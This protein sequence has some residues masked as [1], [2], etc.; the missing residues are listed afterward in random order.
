MGESPEPHVIEGKLYDRG[1]KGT[2]QSFQV[3]VQ[4]DS[5][6]PKVAAAIERELRDSSKWAQRQAVR[7]LDHLRWSD[8][9]AGQSVT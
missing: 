2:M 9:E 7:T 8:D 1:V 6:K 3:R 4:S 5:D